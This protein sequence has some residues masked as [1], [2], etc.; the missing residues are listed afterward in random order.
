MRAL[1]QKQQDLA[2]GRQLNPSTYH[3]RYDGHRPRRLEPVWLLAQAGE[4]LIDPRRKTILLSL[5][6]A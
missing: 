5:M 1:Y 4:E 2:L 3:V 6:V